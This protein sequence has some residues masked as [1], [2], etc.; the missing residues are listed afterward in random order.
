M[1]VPRDPEKYAE[2]KRNLHES[3]LNARRPIVGWTEEEEAILCEKFFTYTL[4]DLCELLPLRTPN[5]IL[6]KAKT[7][8]LSKTELPEPIQGDPS[9]PQKRCTLCREIKDLEN[10]SYELKRGK[11]GYRARCKECLKKQAE[12]R[13]AKKRGETAKGYPIEKACHLCGEV[14]SIHLFRRDNLRDDKR[15]FW[16]KECRKNYYHDPKTTIVNKRYQ[17]LKRPPATPAMQKRYRLLRQYGLT[18]EQYFAL[19]DAQKGVCASCGNPETSI[20]SYTKQVREFLVVDHDHV[21]GKV[22]GLLCSNCNVA[23]GFLQDDPIRI[24]ALL[25]YAKSMK[26]HS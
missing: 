4:S 19:L 22:R 13:H 14:K 3:V 6:G 12:E 2:W 23:L 8:G 15:D 5:S 26:K 24:E 25:N 9:R 20:D 17:P 16:C 21:T 11:Y 7:M 18:I 10:F 1:G